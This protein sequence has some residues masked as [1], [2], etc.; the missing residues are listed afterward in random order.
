MGTGKSQMCSQEGEHH[1]QEF[2]LKK[3]DADL[4]GAAQWIACWP[5]NHRVTG[6]IPSRGTCLGFFQARSPVRGRM[7]GTH[8][9]MFLFLSPSLPPL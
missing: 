9:L 1:P 3:A 7:R 8:I 6:S 4:A 2:F 5:V